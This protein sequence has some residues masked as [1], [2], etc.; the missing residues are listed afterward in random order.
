[1]LAWP[2]NTSKL[3][4]TDGSMNDEPSPERLENAAPEVRAAGRFCRN[5]VFY[6]PH[7]TGGVTIHMPDL[8]LGHRKDINKWVSRQTLDRIRARLDRGEAREDLGDPINLG[9][10]RR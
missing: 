10:A 6:E 4:G 8:K 5:A 1:M 9:P 7:S 3:G 2:P